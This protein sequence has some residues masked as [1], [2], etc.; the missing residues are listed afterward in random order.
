MAIKSTKPAH[1]N[2]CPNTK[3]RNSYRQADNLIAITAMWKHFMFDLP[4][5]KIIGYHPMTFALS[6]LKLVTKMEKNA[7][8]MF[9]D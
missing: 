4:S 8:Q 2:T 7:D 5:L 3:E 9:S 1:V 6:M